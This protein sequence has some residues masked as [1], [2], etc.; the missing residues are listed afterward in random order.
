MKDK[1][2]NI[3]WFFGIFAIVVMICTFDMDYQELWQNLRKAGIWFPA[4]ILLWLFIYL[5]NALSWYIIIRDGK[6]APVPFWK[7][8][9]LTVS[10][11]A[12]NYATPVGLMG[13]EPYRIMELTPYVGGSKA[14]S[15]VILYVMMHIFS[16]FCFWMFSVLLYLVLEPL[17]LGMGIVLAIV[18]VCCLL[19]IYFFMKGYKNG[20]A[21]RTIR[22][23]CHVPFAKK[24]ANRFLVERKDALE[25][26]DAQIAELHRQRKTTFYASLGLEFLARIVGCVEVLFI[27]NILT[28]NVS[29]LSCVLIMA[30]TSLFAN[31]FFFSPMQLGAREGGFA[32]ATG[33]LAIPSAFG[34][35]TG[36]ITRVR[37]LIW[38]VIGVLLMKVGNNT[39]KIEKNE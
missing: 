22:L 36:L 15:S 25:R 37:E 38:I 29:F 17:N 24:W 5:L 13:G 23:L 19:A 10:G 14:T 31:L 34:I 6:H 12:L 9:K 4:V 33:G 2:R 16:H 21:V 27:L 28:S 35:Y 7:V 3:F 18:G 20:M 30:F 11:F 39:G 8:Y 26:V 1:V 32:L